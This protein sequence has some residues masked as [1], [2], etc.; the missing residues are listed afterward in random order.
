[1]NNTHDYTHKIIPQD[2][3]NLTNNHV[4][5]YVSASYTNQTPIIIK[6][7]ELATKKQDTYSNDYSTRPAPNKNNYEDIHVKN[8]N[9]NILYYNN[10]FTNLSNEKTFQNPLPHI[11]NTYTNEGNTNIIPISTQPDLSQSSNSITPGESIGDPGCLSCGG[12]GYY[13]SNQNLIPCE[14]CMVA[15][16]YCAYCH[17][18][19]ILQEN[20]IS[21][22][23]KCRGENCIII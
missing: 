17:N 15:K 3:Q 18:R 14:K 4:S 21:K 22:P 1:M 12:S 2:K 19:G 8:D 5:G 6:N 10:N 7:Y 11:R 20:S 9:K 13:S 23:C 16:N